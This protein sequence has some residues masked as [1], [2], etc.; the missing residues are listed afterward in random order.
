[1]LDSWIGMLTLFLGLAAGYRLAR[2][3]EDYHLA[4]HR[5]PHEGWR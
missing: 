4:R 1:M 2:Y 3:F 5:R